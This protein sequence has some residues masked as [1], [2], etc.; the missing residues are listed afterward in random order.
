MND[1]CN[2]DWDA[3]YRPL[4]GDSKVEAMIKKQQ[5]KPR[6]HKR[7]TKHVWSL[8]VEDKGVK[9]FAVCEVKRGEGH[10]IAMYIDPKATGK[11]YGS[12]LM[13]RAFDDFRERGV[14]RVRTETL[15]KNKGAIRFY[16]RYGFRKKQKLKYMHKFM[17][18]RLV[19]EL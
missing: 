17:S 12:A 18:W 16:E 1:I 5:R 14:K 19:R 8:V 13:D 9:G 15:V 2:A 11:G 6:K 3:F 10:L 4:I 7:N